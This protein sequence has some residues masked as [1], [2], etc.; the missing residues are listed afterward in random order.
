MFG[1]AQPKASSISFHN[2]KPPT[3]FPAGFWLPQIK[4]HNVHYTDKA[5]IWQN[6]FLK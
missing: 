4:R 1:T 6:T 2:F 3:L 5:N